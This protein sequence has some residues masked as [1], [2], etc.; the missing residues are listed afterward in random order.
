MELA[1]T[2][3]LCHVT[4]LIETASESLTKPSSEGSDQ[5]GL[6]APTVNTTQRL[7]EVL[8]IGAS[9]VPCSISLTDCLGQAANQERGT[10]KAPHRL[11][12]HKQ[13]PCPHLGDPS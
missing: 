3:V 4:V 8:G 7:G 2:Q 6:S 13:S 12:C 1:D 10:W 5:V 9:E 11:R